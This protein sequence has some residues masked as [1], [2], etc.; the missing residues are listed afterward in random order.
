MQQL[1]VSIFIILDDSGSMHSIQKQRL[2]V[3]MKLY[4]DS[5][6]EIYYSQLKAI[7]RPPDKRV[8]GGLIL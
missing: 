2:A 6:I 8:S 4:R 5:L 3:W 7:I 1:G